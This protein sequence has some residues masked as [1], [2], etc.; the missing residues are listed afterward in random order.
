VRT[1][2][3]AGSW[4]VPKGLQALFPDIAEAVKALRA[5]EFVLDGESSR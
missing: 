4:D 1:S 2:F 5:Y 3:T